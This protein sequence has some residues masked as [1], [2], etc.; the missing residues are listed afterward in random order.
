MESLRD[1]LSRTKPVCAPLVLN[2]LMAKMAEAEGFEAMAV[3]YK[4]L[5][6]DFMDDSR[7]LED[8]NKLER[9]LHDTIEMNKLLSIEKATVEKE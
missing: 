5:A 1:R 4:E 2:P 7:P 9:Q 6:K 8:W 3:S